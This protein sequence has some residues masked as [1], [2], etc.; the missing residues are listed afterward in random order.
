MKRIAISQRVDVI[1]DY[2]E[3]RDALDQAWHHLLG[4]LGALALPV[5]NAPESLDAW[6]AVNRPLGIVLSGGNDP[7]GSP[8]AAQVAPERDETERRLLD[9]ARAHSLPVLGVC[10]GAQF[11]NLYC[12]GSLCRVDGHVAQRHAVRIQD[13]VLPVLA[14][15]KVVNSFHNLG[16]SP[17]DLGHGLQQAAVAADGTI[18]AFAHD[19]WPWAG[20]LWHPEREPLPGVAQDLN[21]IRQQFGLFA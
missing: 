14:G 3:R 8:D 1:R 15:L 9:H 20:I 12:G 17:N 10:R 21:L 6:L 7:A 19:T 16:I 4:R 5:P 2:G 13:G 11:M 18:E